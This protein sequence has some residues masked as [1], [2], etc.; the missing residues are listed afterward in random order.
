[1][2]RR[3]IVCIGG[4]MHTLGQGIA[5]RTTVGRHDEQIRTYNHIACNVDML[6]RNNITYIRKSIFLA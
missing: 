1:M 6:K 5:K 2:G 4:A 3:K